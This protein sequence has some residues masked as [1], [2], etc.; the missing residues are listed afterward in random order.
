M[1]IVGA[2][3]DCGIDLLNENPIKVREAGLEYDAQVVARVTDKGRTEGEGVEG[4][5]A[6]EVRDGDGAQGA[7]IDFEPDAF[8]SAAA[9]GAAREAII[10]FAEEHFGELNP[11]AGIGPADGPSAARN[12]ADIEVA[13]AEC[14]TCVAGRGVAVSVG[15]FSL[16]TL[17]LG[18]AIGEPADDV[19]VLAGV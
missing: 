17:G 18:A 9:G 7:A 2:E 11:F 19:D 16:Q 13:I 1:A 10:A 14:A 6:T 5:P 12:G 15:A 3:A 4:I 8:A